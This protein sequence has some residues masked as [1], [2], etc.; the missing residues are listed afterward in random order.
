VCWCTPETQKFEKRHRNGGHKDNCNIGCKRHTADLALK[1]SR[2]SP[3][4]LREIFT[5][6]G[7]ISSKVEAWNFTKHKLSKFVNS[8]KM[9]YAF[10]GSNLNTLF[11]QKR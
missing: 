6:K 8:T 1:S 10:A 9:D 4:L 5:S 3:G 7:R 11:R 2:F